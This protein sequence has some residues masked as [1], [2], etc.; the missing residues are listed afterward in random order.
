VF[1]EARGRACAPATRR[2]SSAAL[3]EEVLDTLFRTMPGFVVFSR[4]RRN[5]IEEIDLVVR[6]ESSDPFWRDEGQYLLVE[7]K[8]WSE[9]VPRH[10]FESCAGR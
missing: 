7:C 4:N 8:R 2:P 6:I 1:V 5:D 3:L 10:V 9:P